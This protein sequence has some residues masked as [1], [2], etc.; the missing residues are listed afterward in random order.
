MPSSNRSEMAN[1]NKVPGPG[2]YLQFTK[3]DAPSFSLRGRSQD[4]QSNENPK[5]GP[6]HYDPVYSTTIEKSPSYK[7]GTSKRNLSMA[8]TLNGPG[9]ANYSPKSQDQSFIHHFGNSAR[10]VS[11]DNK[12]PG[13]GAYEVRPISNNISFSMAPRRSSQIFEKTP[14]PGSYSSNSTFYAP[15]YSL[16]RSP[17]K[18]IVDDNHLPGPG[19]YS[20]IDLD[21]KKKPR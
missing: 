17:R 21:T 11:Y 20:P 14:G 8:S 2:S 9:P 1:K 6:G 19:S 7:V 18:P 12:L 13:P 16:S 15:N 3:S 10:S 5:L 4:T